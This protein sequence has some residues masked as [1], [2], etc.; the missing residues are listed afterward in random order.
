MCNSH[1]QGIIVTMNL[2]TYFSIFYLLN[3]II[4]VT[5]YIIYL[6]FSLYVPKVILKGRESQNFHLGSFFHDKILQ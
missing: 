1:R 3:I 2:K 4:S 6:E 5:I